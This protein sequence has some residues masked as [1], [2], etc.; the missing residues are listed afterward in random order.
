MGMTHEQA[1]GITVGVC[2]ECGELITIDLINNEVEGG[3][4][5][6]IPDGEYERVFITCPECGHREEEPRL[7]LNVT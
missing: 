3:E 1:K 5:E 7:R 2:P 6:S 4:F